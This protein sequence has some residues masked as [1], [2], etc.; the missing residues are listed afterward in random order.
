MLRARANRRSRGGP[1]LRAAA[2]R[3]FACRASST[4]VTVTSPSAA[5]YQQSLH[6]VAQFPDISGPAV[7]AQAILRGHRK[8]PV[9]QVFLVRETIQHRN[10][11][12]PEHHPAG[13][14]AEEPATAGHSA[15]NKT[16]AA[17]VVSREF[18]QFVTA[19]TIRRQS[20]F[21][22][23]CCP[24]ARNGRIR[25]P[26]NIFSASVGRSCSSGI[27]SVLPRACSNRPSWCRSQSGRAGR[28]GCYP[29]VSSQ[30]S[31]QTSTLRPACCY[32]DESGQV[33]AATAFFTGDQHRQVMLCRL[34]S[35]ASQNLHQGAA[36][37]RF[38]GWPVLRLAGFC[39]FGRLSSAWLTMDSK[40]GQRDG[41]LYKI[42][43]AKPGGFDRR[44]HGAMAGHDHNRT[45]QAVPPQTT[46]LSKVMPSTSG[47]QMS[48]RT[49]SGVSAG[50]AVRAASPFSA[51]VD[52]VTFVLENFPDEFANIR[53][54]VDDKYVCLV[55]SILGVV[56]ICAT[57]YSI[58]CLMPA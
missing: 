40:L 25:A 8:G 32:M 51:T 4:S 34:L 29:A 16:A 50:E 18:Q 33:F 17:F 12:V 37:D 35:F 9:R 39:S 6:Q 55:H 15:G 31:M 57:A 56:A 26:V 46:L 52:F 45:I 44:L 27:N 47:I 13:R 2:R 11:P 54:V 1:T 43:S 21:C 48:S 38:I 58:S 49:R 14:S 5:Q 42:M 19:L 41:F 7:V 3:G 22:T 24:R 36:A 53:F 30:C 23:H 28:C 10:G 20:R